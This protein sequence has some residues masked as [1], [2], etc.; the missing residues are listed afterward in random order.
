MST[1]QTLP[2][3][4]FQSRRPDPDRL[5]RPLPDVLAELV[6][7]TEAAQKH[8][9]IAESYSA[10]RTRAA[11]CAEKLRDAER[12]DLEA[13]RAAIAQGHSVP[14]AKAP[15]LADELARARRQVAVAT[16]LLTEAAEALLV[17]AVPYFSQ[18]AERAGSDAE[19]A[20]AELA[21]AL[22]AL[23]QR[24]VETAELFATAGTLAK[25]NASG[26]LDLYAP[27]RAD[28][29]PRASGS[30]RQAV[31]LLREERD[32]RHA[33]LAQMERERA[34]E[35]KLGLPPG[36]QVWR[37]GQTLIVGESGELEAVER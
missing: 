10:A 27:R 24:F 37:E 16:G 20:L 32:E 13:E 8:A 4:D 1:K 18:A 19:Q 9:Q 21:D 25:L 22:N 33:R 31:A 30:V 2:R 36:T 29:V 34:H 26:E 7:G 11:A 17:A 5:V 14:K 6:A 35:L 12:K 3:F 15:G 28:P 23:E